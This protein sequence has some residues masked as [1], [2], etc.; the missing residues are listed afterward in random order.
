MVKEVVVSGKL[1]VKDLFTFLIYHN[2]SSIGGKL[3]GALGLLGLILAPVLLFQKDLLTGLVF[4]AVALMYVVITPLDFY[5]K[6]LRQL[7]SNPVFKNKMTF[8]FSDASLRTTM[9][10]GA[11]EIVWTDIVKIV[12]AKDYFFYLHQRSPRTY[13]T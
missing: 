1:T 5:S 6:A 4:A 8:A 7:R 3:T 11:S 12:D 2:Y 13:S 10:T 9:Y